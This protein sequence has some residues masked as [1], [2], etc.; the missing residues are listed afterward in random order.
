MRYI[1]IAAATVSCCFALP[2]DADTPAIGDRK[3]GAVQLPFDRSTGFLNGYFLR[4]PRNGDFLWNGAPVGGVVLKS[5]LRKW[6][7]LPHGAG[8]LFVAFEPGTP[9]SRAGWVRKQ[10]IDSG[11]CEQRRCAEIGWNVKRPV[12]N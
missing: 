10:V 4:V 11:L 2:S 1:V 12:V 5:Y 7:V 8:H 9:Q 3:I 6:A